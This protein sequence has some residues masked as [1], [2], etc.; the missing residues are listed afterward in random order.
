M[1]AILVVSLYL[2]QMVM[3]RQARVRTM[4]TVLKTHDLVSLVNTS[5]VDVRTMYTIY[6]P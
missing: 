4:P 1:A 6:G 3:K 5:L 2:I